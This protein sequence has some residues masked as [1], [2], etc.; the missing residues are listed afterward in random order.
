MGGTVFFVGHWLCTTFDPST[1]T[2]MTIEASLSTPR[3]LTFI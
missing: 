1:R 2:L 3:H